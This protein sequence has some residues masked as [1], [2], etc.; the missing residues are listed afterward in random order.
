[1]RKFP[2]ERKMTVEQ[3]GPSLD[4]HALT[5]AGLFRKMPGANVTVRG[6][7][8]PGQKPLYFGLV[9]LRD[10]EDRS[11]YLKTYRKLAQPPDSVRAPRDTV[12]ELISTPCNLGGKRWWFTCPMEV[13][14][15][16]CAKRVA[17]LY[18]P[19]GER[20]LGCRH[21]FDL[22]YRSAQEHDRRVDALVKN[23]E[24]LEKKAKST[25]IGDLLLARKAYQKLARKE[26]NA[27]CDLAKS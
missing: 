27:L 1:M 25:K 14:G 8:P 13:N 16:K 7:A 4:I 17:K 18:L 15:I 9:L 11:L 21:C 5:R 2:W 3:A 26:I 24:R 10:E 20:Y 22:T 19:P 23:P 12:I 6:A